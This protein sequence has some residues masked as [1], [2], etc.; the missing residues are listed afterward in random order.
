MK[1]LLAIWRDAQRYRWLR[2]QHW[3]FENADV[4]VAERSAVRLGGLTFSFERLDRICDEG[5]RREPR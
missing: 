3:A 5:R 1:W 2:N 4:V